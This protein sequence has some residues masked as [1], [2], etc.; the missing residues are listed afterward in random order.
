MATS[1]QT[2]SIV[3][4]IFLLSV[5]AWD[6]RLFILSLVLGLRWFFQPLIK[7]FLNAAQ[8]EA[9]VESYYEDVTSNPPKKVP[10]PSLITNEKGD[11]S[12][13][14]IVPAFREEKRLGRMLDETLEYLNKRSLRN[15]SFTW[16]IIVVDDGS[17]DNT[18]NEALK[19]S[20]KEE[21]GRIRVLKLARN[22]GKGG[23]IKKGMMRAR[24]ELLLLVDADGA[25]RFSDVEKLEEAMQ[26]F[27][28]G[29][30]L[31]FGSRTHLMEDEKLRRT[32]IRGFVSLVFHTVLVGMLVP[33]HIRDTQCGFKL[34]SRKA[35]RDIFP[36]QR[37]YGWAFDCELLF[38]ARIKFNY[39]VCEVGVH[40]VDV[41]GSTLSVTDASLEMIRDIIL[42]AGL[43]RLHIW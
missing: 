40:W 26:R 27:H 21:A 36:L 5:F 24:G 6:V 31:V 33:G 7:A 17:P 34:I 23:A 14:V 32:G 10:F 43:Y 8:P 28:D 2:V 13:S 38:L 9:V 42:M 18:Y 11:V 12:L 35:A 3:A 25:T 1:T 29:Q 15:K 37:F 39:P 30:G 4:A 19:Y 20:S 22:H 41:E 16:E